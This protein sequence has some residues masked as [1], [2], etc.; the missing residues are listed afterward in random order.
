MGIPF[1]DADELAELGA[2]AYLTIVPWAEGK[3]FEGALFLVNARG[4]PLEFTYNRV[5]TPYGFLWRKDDIRR[6]AQR[7]LTASVLSTCPVTPKLIL[8]LAQE[9]ASELFC[10]DIEVPMP[11]GRIAPGGM[12]ASFAGD[13]VREATDP[14]DPVNLFWFPAA[15]ADSTAER[16]LVGELA[17]RGLLL[18]PFDRAK[19]GLDEVYRG[20]EGA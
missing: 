6:H 13:E 16:Q 10:E 18:E 15:P 14:P 2:A 9:V 19:G 8:C 11:V 20:Q 17:R 12:V 1:R 3:G 4:E 7:R 5:E